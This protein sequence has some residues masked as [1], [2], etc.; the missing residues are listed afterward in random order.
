MFNKTE[1]WWFVNVWWK[2]KLKYKWND[3]SRINDSSYLLFSYFLNSEFI[4]VLKV[5]LTLQDKRAVITFYIK[6]FYSEVSHTVTSCLSISELWMYLLMF[7][8]LQ[9]SVFGS[10]LDVSPGQ[11]VELNRH[12][13]NRHSVISLSMFCCFQQNVC[14]V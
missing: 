7:A 9:G 3:Y 12:S 11:Y 13:V 1:S 4:A 14:K 6:D 8:P 5:P 10:M 2:T